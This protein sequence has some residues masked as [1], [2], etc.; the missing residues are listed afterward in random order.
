MTKVWDCYNPTR[1]KSV[2]ANPLLASSFAGLPPALISVAGL[3]PLRDQGVAYA[4][5]MEAEGCEV[6]LDVYKGIPHG[7]MLMPELG[8]SKQ[9]QR[10]V[11]EWMRGI[12]E[13]A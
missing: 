12:L 1:D 7:W 2:L 8:Q 5:A 4:R 10:G 11:A 9:F 3:D 6:V 13:R